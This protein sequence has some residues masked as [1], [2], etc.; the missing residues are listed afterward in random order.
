ML[1]RHVHAKAAE[2]PSIYFGAANRTMFAAPAK[3]LQS[4]LL[5]GRRHHVFL[6]LLA[7]ILEVLRSS[8][9]Q[10]LL[11]AAIASIVPRVVVFE[12]FPHVMAPCAVMPLRTCSLFAVR[13]Y[14]HASDVAQTHWYYKHEHIDAW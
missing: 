3:E 10:A 11:N 6:D 1:H 5:R 8:R 2:Y 12:P 7:Q 4:E 9:D 13:G 14:S